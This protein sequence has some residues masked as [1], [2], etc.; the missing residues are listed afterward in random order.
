M[1]NERVITEEQVEQLLHEIENAWSK[2]DFERMVSLFAQDA[3]IESPAVVRLLNRKEGVC[4]G[5]DEIRLLVRAMMQRGRPW[6][7]HGPPLIRGNTVAIEYMS[8]SSD[9][10]S[11]SVDLIEIRDG[12][13]QS[14]RAYPGWRAVTALSS[15]P[16]S[17][18]H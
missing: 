11:F 17:E 16:S 2:K 1:N 14:L 6:G 8:A 4:R 18:S 10:D 3:T 9:R 5:R 7:K 15:T 13:I 12:R